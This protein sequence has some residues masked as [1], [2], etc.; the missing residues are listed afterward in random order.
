MITLSA[1]DELVIDSVAGGATTKNVVSY[2]EL[3]TTTFVPN[4]YLGQYVAASGSSWLILSPG[5]VTTVIEDINIYCDSGSMDMTVQ[6]YYSGA[7][8]AKLYGCHISVG[9]TL[10]YNHKKGWTLRDKY[11]RIK[12]E[13]HIEVYSKNMTYSRVV[14]TSD[15]INDNAVANTME[16][17]TGLEF[18]GDY[19]NKRYWF[20]FVIFYVTSLTTN[21]AR[22]SIDHS[23][24]TDV[25]YHSFYQ[26]SAS[27]R[28]RNAGLNAVDLPASASVGGGT[29]SNISIIEG[30]L[31][32]NG[33]PGDYLTARFA[34]ELNTST[35]T[36]KAGSFGEYYLLN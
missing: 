10:S 26:S 21:G 7:N 12:E 18:S 15:V 31:E 25:K 30:I 36:A 16:D 24:L 13:E 34:S 27:A 35:I 8:Q 19:S 23:D 5:G 3:T 1:T 20:R 32:T 11:G 29:V 6:L 14:L 9:E 2:R 17:I 22:F 33:S 4:K 28:V